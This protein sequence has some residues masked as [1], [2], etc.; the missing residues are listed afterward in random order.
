MDSWEDLKAFE[1]PAR[2][3]ETL[4]GPSTASSSDWLDS[5]QREV[6]IRDWQSI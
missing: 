1:S 2:F 5:V 4:I 6:Y 3:P